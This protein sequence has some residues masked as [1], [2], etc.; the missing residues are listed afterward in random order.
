MFMRADTESRPPMGNTWASWLRAQQPGAAGTFSFSTRTV[1]NLIFGVGASDWL[2]TCHKASVRTAMRAASIKG[3]L[4]YAWISILRVDR[5]PRLHQLQISPKRRMLIKRRDFDHLCLVNGLRVR[6]HTCR[7]W[8]AGI[9]VRVAAFFR[10]RDIEDKYRP[11]LLHSK[12]PVTGPAFHDI[13]SIVWHFKAVFRPRR[14]FPNKYYNA[15]RISQLRTDQGS[16]YLLQLML[17]F[18]LPKS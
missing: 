13:T 8:Q 17:Q 12:L 6:F 4:S 10:G 9:I 2:I 3:S 1:A 5:P 15:K 16:V 14:P 18:D 7:S 11:I